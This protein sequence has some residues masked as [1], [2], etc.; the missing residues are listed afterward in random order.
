MEYGSISW[1]DQ[2]I[3]SLLPK[4]LIFKR[5]ENN[6][7][8]NRLAHVERIY[9]Y[10]HVLRALV[11]C[12]AVYISIDRHQISTFLIELNIYFRL[13]VM[14]WQWNILSF[15][16]SMVVVVW[17]SSSPHFSTTKQMSGPME[18]KDK[19]WS[20]R[21]FSINA[22]CV[23]YSRDRI[24]VLCMKNGKSCSIH[25][26]FKQLR[27]S[28]ATNKDAL[29]NWKSICRNYFAAPRALCLVLSKWNTNKKP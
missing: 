25:Y 6:I 8:G 1:R 13:F 7:P 18:I 26:Q 21:F 19:L 23:F 14:V 9:A 20:G 22:V 5:N 4:S 10:A 12:T 28:S 17:N 11:C 16:I 24:W 27:Y 3:G 2:L 29:T 15:S